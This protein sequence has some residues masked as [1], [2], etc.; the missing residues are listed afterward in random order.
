MIK[1]IPLRPSDIKKIVKMIEYVSPGMSP[2][3]IGDKN[4]IHFPFNIVHNFLP[5]HMKFLQ[6]CYVAVED[7]EPLGLITLI[8]DGHSR[9]R[10]K[11]NRLILGMNAYDIG[12]QL[13]D[14][15]VN[16]YGGAGVEIFITVIDENYPEAIA[17][18]KNACAFRHYSKINVWE[19][20][21]AASREINVGHSLFRRAEISDAGKLIELDAESILPHLRAS[22]AKTVEDFKFDR[23][24]K[25][26]DYLKGYRSCKYVLDNP[27]KNSIEGLLSVFTFNNRHFWVDITVSMAYMQYYED[28]VNFAI[29]AIHQENAFAGIYVGVKDYHQAARHMTE[30]LSGLNFSMCGNFQVLLKDYWQPIKDYRENKVP[31]IIFPDMTSP[32]CNI[33]RFISES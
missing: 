26:I 8:P 25:L 14:Y 24:S 13:I 6:E 15:V 31:A 1:I 7:N 32:A 30:V 3:M 11:I 20:N 21:P 33:M 9:N 28:I 23:K 16:K 27:E 10:W 18:F 2:D 5:V 29:S 12:K 19:Y 22:L 4:F 17:L